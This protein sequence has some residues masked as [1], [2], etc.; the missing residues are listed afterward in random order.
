[1][2]LL[3]ILKHIDSELMNFYFERYESDDLE[4]LISWLNKSG[5]NKKDIIEIFQ[6]YPIFIH[7]YNMFLETYE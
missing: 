1:M 6:D 4:E 5:N 2:K 7:A 3:K